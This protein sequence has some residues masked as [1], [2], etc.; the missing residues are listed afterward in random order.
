VRGNVDDAW[1]PTIER[2]QREGG[3]VVPDTENDGALVIGISCSTTTLS[4]LITEMPCEF[5]I[6]DGDYASLMDDSEK[7]ETEIT[8]GLM[9]SAGGRAIL[10]WTHSEGAV[11]ATLSVDP[12]DA[13]FHRTVSETWQFLED[14]RSALT[15]LL[16]TPNRAAPN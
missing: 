7:L 8:H 1:A 4:A 2:F 5:E 6:V 3:T 16:R 13:Q 12:T 10:T 15:P 14:A 9:I 11:S